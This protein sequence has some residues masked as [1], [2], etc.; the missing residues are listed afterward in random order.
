M[1]KMLFKGGNPG[2]KYGSFHWF[3]YFVDGEVF[4]FEWVSR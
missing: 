2:G 1:F 3:V 4:E